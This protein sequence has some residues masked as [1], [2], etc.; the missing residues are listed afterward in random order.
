M[1]SIEQTLKLKK[2][3]SLQEADDLKNLLTIYLHFGEIFPRLVHTL[4]DIHW[5]LEKIVRPAFQ[6]EPLEDKQRLVP[7]PWLQNNFESSSFLSIKNSKKS[8]VKYGI[9]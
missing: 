6:I 4:N 3:C 5:S 8:E 7:T 2:V 9:V 1:F